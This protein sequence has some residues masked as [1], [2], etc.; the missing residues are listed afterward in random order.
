MFKCYL[1]VIIV[2]DKKS[3]VSFLISSINAVSVFVWKNHACFSSVFWLWT[4]C[5]YSRLMKRL[6]KNRSLFQMKNSTCLKFFKLLKLR[7]VDYI[8]MLNFFVI[9]MINWFKKIWKSSKKNY[10]SWKENRILL[11][12]QIIIFLTY[13]F[14][15]SMQMLFFLCYLTISEQISAL[16][17]AFQHLL[18]L[19]K[20]FNKFSNIFTVVI[21]FLF[22]KI[23]IYSVDLIFF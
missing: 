10:V 2:L 20:I 3:S 21:I 1:F 22:D 5:D 16:K 12:L 18:S 4:L 23:M 9:M 7:N 14:L 13:W 11:F 15:K 6:K 17:K 19:F 8:I